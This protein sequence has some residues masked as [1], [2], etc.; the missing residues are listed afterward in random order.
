MKNKFLFA[1]MAMIL[2][3]PL[4]MMAQNGG[5]KLK[6]NQSEVVITTNMS[7]NGC[8][9]EIEKELGYQKGVVEVEGDLATKNVRVVYK[10]K[11]NTAENLVAC[12]Q[13]L[14]YQATLLKCC[15]GAEGEGHSCSGDHSGGHNCSG[16]NSNKKGCCDKKE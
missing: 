14:G 8:K 1:A 4:S 5:P 15:S 2:V 9:T 11:K 13:K 3:L 7:C 6:K 10:T 16:D 12:V